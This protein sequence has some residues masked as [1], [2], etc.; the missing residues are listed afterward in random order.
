MIGII[1]INANK[2]CIRL[3][4]KK[5]IVKIITINNVKLLTTNKNTLTSFR[6]Y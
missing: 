2:Y 3:L 4:S 1:N 6:I 5:N